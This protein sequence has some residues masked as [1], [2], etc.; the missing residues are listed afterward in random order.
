MS[1]QA[2]KEDL[3]VRSLEK[4][5]IVWVDV[6]QPSEP[7][8]DWLAENYAFHPLALEDCLSHA[9]MP[10]IDDYNTY[11]FLVLHFPVFDREARITLPAEVDVFVGPD[12]MVTVQGRLLMHWERRD[13]WHA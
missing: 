1:T 2:K 6:R 10:K 9:Q 4:D 7:E 11:L 12:Y 5:G 8:I 3:N 13:S